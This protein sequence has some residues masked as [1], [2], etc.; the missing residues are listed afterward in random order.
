MVDLASFTGPQA[1]GKAYQQML[2]NDA[3]APGSVD[4][5][6]ASNMVRLREETAS[7]LCDAYTDLHI[8]YVAGSRPDLERVLARAQPS[9]PDPAAIAELT[10]SLAA[11]STSGGLSTMR[12]GGYS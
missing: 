8:G 9:N 5:E 10:S 7:P 6:I 11:R 2:D 4:R 3:H 1:F 12:F